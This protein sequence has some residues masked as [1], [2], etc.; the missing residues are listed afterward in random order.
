MDG[1]DVIISGECR[2]G[3]EV[4]GVGRRCTE[5]AGEKRQGNENA[6]HGDDIK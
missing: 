5:G 6:N 3:E 2:V 4:P 1:R